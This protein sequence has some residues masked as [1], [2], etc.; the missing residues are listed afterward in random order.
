MSYT[1]LKANLAI[2]V[3]EIAAHPLRTLLVS[4]GMI[5][6]VALAIVPAAV[7]GGT[8]AAAVERA[9]EIGT[10]LVQIGVDPG[11]AVFP[12]E[13]DL[14]SLAA[15]LGPDARVSGL[16]VAPASLVV[17]EALDPRVWLLGC[18][19]EISST[20]GKKA[21]CGR[22]PSATPAAEAGAD[23]VT[24]V[25]LELGLVE[26][27][28][29]VGVDPSGVVGRRMALAP[30]GPADLPALIP[31]EASVA[32]ARMLHVVGVIEDERD[33]ADAMGV[34]DDARFSK[35]VST[36][37]RAV[38]I[39]PADAPWRSTGLGVYL[40]RSAVPGDRLDWL[41]IRVEPT[42][43][44]VCAAQAEKLLVERGRSPL[45]YTNAVWPIMTAPEMQG[46]LVLHEVFFCLFVTMGL[47]VLANLLLLSGWQ[48][49]REI[50]LRRAEGARR[51]DIFTQFVCEGVLLA[52]VGFA[53][54]LACGMGLA[55]LR[56]ALDPNVA[57]AATL[58]WS[59]TIQ[60]GVV[61]TV[62]AV[63]ASAYPAWRASKHDPMSLLRRAG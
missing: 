16:R 46:Y 14:P 63:V 33:D 25:A 56:V 8:R 45:L 52:I 48:R 49:R 55:E 2:A 28:L 43:V 1:A 12:I 18:D 4:Q 24:E 47:L 19:D 35:L 26:H 42:L 32:G 15:A 29:G 54:G 9:R 41:F 58:P 57:V 13:A 37:L 31:A 10:D 20:R 38:G 21:L 50:A 40:P 59:D 3:R 17:G 36:L 11:G 62:G 53:V 23:P 39:A 5:W 27:L 7:I 6:A 34:R 61:L 60:A 30:T 44:G 22:Y 51:L